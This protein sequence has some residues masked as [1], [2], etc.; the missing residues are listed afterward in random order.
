M[1]A[2]MKMGELSNVDLKKEVGYG[3][4]SKLTAVDA[5]CSNFSC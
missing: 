1:Y 3:S 2:C 4:Q 5:L